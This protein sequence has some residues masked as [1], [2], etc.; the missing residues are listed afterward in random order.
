MTLPRAFP[1]LCLASILH[2]A[3]GQQAPL[4][5]P[6]KAPV[7]LLSPAESAKKLQIA[8]GY[9]LE[10]VLSEPAIKEPVAIAFDGDG[11]MFVVEMR[12]Y[13][14]EV[15]GKDEITPVSCVSMHTDSDGDG[16]YDKHTVFADK[17]TLP[18]MVL[19]L[20]KG[21]VLIGE[22]NTLDIFLWTDTDGDGVSDKK[23]LFFAGGPRGGNLEHQPSGL[24]WSLD[25]WI[26]TTYNAYRIRWTPQ[27]AIKEPTGPNNGQWGLTQDDYGKPWFV[28]AGGER[29]PLNFQVPIV[30]GAFR[31]KGEFAPGFAEVWPAVGLADVQGGK[32]RFRPEDKTLNHFTATC[33]IDVYRGDRLPAELHGDLF[34]GEPV[35]RLVRRAKVT[36]KD[37][38][39]TLS[40]PYE[41]N[42]FIRSTDPNFRPLNMNTAPDGTLYIVDMYRG[43]IQEGNWTR[44]GSYL[45]SVIVEHGMDKNI[46][47][48]RIWRLVHDTTR[49]GPQPG[50]NSETPAQLVAHLAH[51][52]G[53]WRDTAQKLLI[54]KQDKA[55][56]PALSAMA[57]TD[58]NHLARLHALWTLEG[59]DALTPALV[60]EALRD[61]HPQLRVAA[62]RV[63]ESLIKKGD[64]TLA[65]DVQAAAK[66]AAAEVA[67]QSM[68]T[69]KLLALGDWKTSIADLA[70]ANPAA[71][72]QEISSQ[73][74]NPAAP[75]ASTAK[76]TA[77]EQKVFKAGEANYQSV[78]IAC[79]GTD[80]K[81][82]PMLGAA[83]GA[84]LAPS[85]IGS[86]TVT[87]HRNG[88][89]YVML[90]GLT[91]DIDGKKY[92]GQMVSMATNDDKWIASTLSYIRNSFGNRAGF[93]T[94]A[95]VASVRA[96]TKDRTQSWTIA[97]LRAALPQ[98]LSN[99]KAW[100]LTASHKPA[101]CA[102]AIDGDAG[103]RY[104]TGA[105]QA[106][107][108]WLQ[109]ELPQETAVAGVVLDS[110][111][112]PNDYP[113]GYKVEVSADGQAWSKP[114]AIGKGTPGNTDI[115]FDPVKAK[116][117]RITQTGSV[118]G[119]FWSI[120]ELQV[121]APKAGK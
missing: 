2:T 78:C 55:V 45:R 84:M 101:D 54:L 11:R 103:S 113:R 91:G 118:N 40:N 88:S 80:G 57:R 49:R 60:R 64:T 8:P 23:E 79:H 77:E 70:K 116:H 117:I 99:R 48:G 33:G 38:L 46:G 21:R 67:V 47:C 27:G 18:R 111:K 81:G 65:A 17:L 106:P 26:Y 112:S 41:K 28:N 115:A 9:R 59:L 35:G 51:P 89:I 66:D 100:K 71:G 108:M 14:Q 37:G 30:Y 73:I 7:P 56:V 42:E 75:A 74:L 52:N 96:A 69:T 6:A 110:I 97:E 5:W 34:F 63:S 72:V 107:G 15:D 109:I 58:K 25:N 31:T 44:E 39:T 62:I 83:P 94:P 61:A 12:S 114:V 22:T 43:I 98:A 32:G 104:T 68:L 119:L 3:L 19:P 102:A 121:L 20:D 82:A 76:F 93:I 1:I 90:H 95:E 24:M 92:E 53:W 10:L 85:L 50:M 29:G 4:A 105:S 13:M 120:H 36:V 87:G 86:K 16:T